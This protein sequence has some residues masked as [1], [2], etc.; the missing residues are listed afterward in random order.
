MDDKVMLISKDVVFHEELFSYKNVPAI[1]PEYPLPILVFDEDPVISHTAPMHMKN[2]SPDH[3]AHS[4]SNVPSPA[5]SPAPFLRRSSRQVTK[6]CWLNDSV[7]SISHSNSGSPIVTYIA[8]SH[9]EFVASISILQEPGTYLQ[10]STSP[11]WTAAMQAPLDALESNKTW[12]VTP[13]HPK[14]GYN[15]IE[16]IDYNEIFSL[17]AKTVTI[18]LFFAIAA[19]R[20]AK[21]FL[22][23]EIN[24]RSPQGLAVTQYSKNSTSRLRLVPQTDLAFTSGSHQLFDSVIFC[25]SREGN[26]ILSNVPILNLRTYLRLVKPT[27]APTIDPTFETNNKRAL[28]DAPT[29][30]K[31]SQRPRKAKKLDPDFLYFIV[32]GDRN[33]VLNKIPILLTVESDPKTF[34]EAMTSRDVA[35]WK[36]AVNDEMDS[37]LANNTWVLTDLP[38]GSKAI[39]VNGSLGESTILMDLFKRLKQ[40]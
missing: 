12:E 3:N 19:A 29:E 38:P 14:K 20:V 16:G 8:P 21:Y 39:D 28:I 34:T 33:I 25:S 22:G 27:Q 7:C 23:L 2:S 1:E 32:E 10:V 5:A 6:R 31:R 18:R 40:D 17:V 15:Q 36:E 9:S 13:L 37:L 4:L 11:E 30:L 24:V 35:F 26:C